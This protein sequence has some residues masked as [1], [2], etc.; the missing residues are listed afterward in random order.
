MNFVKNG[1]FAEKILSPWAPRSSDGA[2]PEPADTDIITVDGFNLLRMS[3]GGLIHQDLDVNEMGGINAFTIKIKGAMVGQ[4]R[5]LPENFSPVQSS[6]NFPE[7][8][9]EKPRFK[10]LSSDEP[11]PIGYLIFNARFVS[12]TVVEPPATDF[13]PFYSLRDF[14]DLE[15]TFVTTPNKQCTHAFIYIW[16]RPYTSNDPKYLHSDVVITNIELTEY[17]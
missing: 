2:H 7:M 3:P 11:E 6:A 17:R 15:W 10:A 14:H 8:P 4:P 1:N 13:M 12:G 5:E 9:D 16:C